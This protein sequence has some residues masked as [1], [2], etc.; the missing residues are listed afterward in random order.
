M[1]AVGSIGPH[2][3]MKLGFRGP[4]RQKVRTEAPTTLPPRRCRPTKRYRLSCFGSRLVCDTNGLSTRLTATPR[5]FS[6]ISCVVH[7]LGGCVFA[8]ISD[9]CLRRTR[10]AGNLDLSVA[11]AH[12]LAKHFLL[13][14]Q[15]ICTF[16]SA[17]P[18]SGPPG[19]AR[20]QLFP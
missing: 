8:H 15:A 11:T 5:F 3:P 7:I 16:R 12:Y 1:P 10:V 17:G 19:E 6:S 18:L 20:V 13:V 14:S 2:M 4:S 9:V